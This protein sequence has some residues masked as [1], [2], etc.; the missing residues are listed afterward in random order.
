M[1]GQKCP[2]EKFSLRICKT[3]YFPVVSEN[4]FN[5]QDTKTPAPKSNAKNTDIP[6][7]YF[8]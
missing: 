3:N 1:S 8:L 2:G 5:I 4:E 7:R 6:A